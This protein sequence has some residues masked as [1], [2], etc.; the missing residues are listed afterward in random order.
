MSAGDER[1]MA[2]PA[3]KPLQGSLFED[4]YL[5]RTLGTIAYIPE[6]ALTELVANAWDAGASQVD[7]LIP[8]Q[9]GLPLIVEDDGCGL[10]EAQFKT[11]WM[12]LAYDR[13]KH[14]GR[15]A[16]FP[17]ERKDWR[18]P[19]YGR[20]GIGRHGLLCFGDRYEVETGREGRL[21]R[22]VV[23][24]TSG[25]HP[26]VLLS[27]VSEIDDRHGTRLEVLAERNLPD[28]S[29]I[30]DILSGR[31][32][33]DPRFVLRVNG[34]SVPL[35]EHS[36]LLERRILEIDDKAKVEAF[37][38]DSTRAARKTIR[39]GVAFWIGGRLVGA[40]SWTVG[41]Q[42]V[43]D[44][45]SQLAKRYTVVV[46]SED[47]FDEV[48]SDWSGFKVTERVARL[49]EAVVKYVREKFVELS[50]ER[51][52]ETKES[53]LREHREELRSLSPLARHEVAEFVTE[54]T[55][56]EVGIQAETLSLAVLALIR[57]ERS[58]SGAALLEKLGKLEES[59]IAGLDRL[60]S[61]WSVRDA[62][63]VLDEIDSRLAV[64]EALG[65]ASGDRGV[66][67][68]Q[69]IHP[70]VTQARWLFGP[71]F[72]SHEYATNV[73]LQNAV[74]KVFGQR[75]DKSAFI[76]PKKRPDLVALSDASLCAVGTEQ[77]DSVSGLATM[78]DVLLIEVKRG[79]ARIGREELDQA[80]GYVED[81]LNCGLLDGPPFI[82][83][84]VVGHELD[85]RT[86]PIRKIGE[87]P[88]KGRIQATTF[89]QLVR[90]AHQRLFRLRDRLKRYEA[91][92]SNE[93]LARVLQEPQQMPLSL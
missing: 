20:N 57:L 6:V 75:I 82:S 72:D 63:T 56:E 81:I 35:E 84:F 55:K 61:D 39:Q 92:S 50:Q 45:R 16:E 30:R 60:L 5:L 13:V 59:D 51:I 27:A 21:C 49:N 76:D 65:K 43:I 38:V 46:K 68:V 66:A 74:K 33:H 2:A 93:L 26:F 52:E 53:V 40:P 32:L 37:F 23:G 34:Q 17:P 1:Q 44:G 47:L 69:T 78:R 19:A 48:V 9:R 87:Q 41:D 73:S 70:L 28:A 88:E 4:D 10:T 31:F 3:G 58:H 8:E 71:E 7:I 36:G 15:L 22:F 80:S 42:A 91:L 77:I 83:A 67:E 24:T 79:G 62:L 89:G 14:Q 29:R 25:E 85:Q 12:T 90:T 54:I 11:R 64:V 86:T 18:R